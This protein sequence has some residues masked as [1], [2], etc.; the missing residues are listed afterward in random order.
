MAVSASSLSTRRRLPL[1]ALAAVV[2]FAAP[3]VAQGSLRDELTKLF[4]FGD[5]G[6]PL[7]LDVD[8][9][10]HG[11]HFIPANQAG[12]Q[13]L[14]AFL[15]A[16]IGR[17]V[18]NLPLGATSSGV[19]FTFEGGVPV[20]TSLSA[21]P[22]F[23]ERAQTLGRGRVYVGLSMT[24]LH[25]QEIR[26]VS[27]DDLALNFAH[28]DVG[29]QGLGDPTFENDIFQVRL[30]LDVNVLVTAAQITWGVVDFVDIGLVVP[31]VRT[32]LSGTSVAQ[33]FPFGT[34]AF[35]SFGTEG[36]N[37]I[38]SEATSASGTATGIGDIATRLK[39]NVAR[40]ENVA[41]AVL[42][43]LRLPT[44]AAEDFLGAGEASWRAV[45]ILSG[46][47][48]GFAPHVNTGYLIRTGDLD[49]D[50]FLAT[51]GFDQLIGSWATVAADFIS[52]WQIGESK[53]PLPGPIELAKPFERTVPS[54]DIPNR[55]D[56]A[57][58]VSFGLKATTQRGITLVGN[59]I[60]PIGNGGVQPG[61]L[62]TAGIEYTF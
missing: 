2:F 60:V 32:T 23:A 36:G 61:A 9:E 49:N 18:A 42:A 1:L 34:T 12:N 62:W 57:L 22:I 35:H 14:L 27:L 41:V 5:C 58:A 59:V 39:I 53:L 30:G 7:C 17:S 28:Q 16:A 43:D 51:V 54:S 45:G 13:A 8:P 31:L 52:E 15:D 40:A 56:D 20:T 48:S 44:G 37:P 6:Q 29:E 10:F 19:T 33:I 55:R 4:T 24:G 50:A 11:Q 25:F 21:G 38:L 3:L 46:R 47:W 26:G